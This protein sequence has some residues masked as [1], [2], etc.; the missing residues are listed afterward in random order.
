MNGGEIAWTAQINIWIMLTDLYLTLNQTHQATLSV[1]EAAQIAWAH[2][3]VL[4]SVSSV[5]NSEN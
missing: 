4:F 5:I 2:P 3:D 1:D